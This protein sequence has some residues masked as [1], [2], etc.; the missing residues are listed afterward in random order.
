LK[1]IN[2]VDDLDKDLVAFKIN[3]EDPEDSVVLFNGNISETLCKTASYN[4][5]FQALS[6][7]NL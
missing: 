4:L 7:L 5:I 6:K 2:E 1:K 3:Y